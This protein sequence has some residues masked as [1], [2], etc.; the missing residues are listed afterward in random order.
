MV[1]DKEVND[2][3]QVNNMDTAVKSNVEKDVDV[4]KHADVKKD[5]DIKKDVD[6]KKHAD[7]KK[8][9]NE[10]IIPQ[11]THEI[12]INFMEFYQ[13]LLYHASK[14]V[15]RRKFKR[16]FLPYVRMKYPG[17]DN[18][19][20]NEYLNRLIYNKHDD[21]V[22]LNLEVN[23]D[24]NSDSQSSRKIQVKYNKFNLNEISICEYV[25]KG[26]PQE[27]QLYIDNLC[28]ERGT[29]VDN[30]EKV[31]K[32]NDIEFE[33][34]NSEGKSLGVKNINNEFRYFDSFISKKVGDTVRINLPDNNVDLNI[35]KGDYDCKIKKIILRK[36]LTLPELAK[37]LNITEEELHSKVYSIILKEFSS[38]LRMVQKIEVFNIVEDKLGALLSKN[39]SPEL[40]ERQKMEIQQHLANNNQ[41]NIDVDRYTKRRAVVFVFLNFYSKQYGVDMK[42]VEDKMLL[43]KAI[44]K[45]TQKISLHD[46]R[47]KI[48]NY[49][50]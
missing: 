10:F 15:D 17:F 29:S 2:V 18:Q 3:K 34:M 42:E 49:N 30:V 41:K 13:Y 48:E 19:M 31:A 28:K 45:D 5:A 6:V 46:L 39:I 35:N 25:W 11:E 8:D 32:D 20:Y 43:H 40:L 27:V 33:L 38:L 37:S 47:K 24:K 9:S 21:G 44:K 14:L 50:L 26:S 12:D 16:N 1:Q 22:L 23:A 7:V 36:S 4:K